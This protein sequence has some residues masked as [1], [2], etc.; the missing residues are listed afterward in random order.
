MARPAVTRTQCDREMKRTQAPA[1]PIGEALERFW[2]GW[3][4]YA[5]AAE[6]GLR[7]EAASKLA[8]LEELG[9]ALRRVL[10]QRGL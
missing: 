7:Y 9:E 4:D 10:R 6:R 8:E 5:L 2:E 1:G 3:Q